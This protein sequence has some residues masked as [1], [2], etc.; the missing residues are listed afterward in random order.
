[1]KISRVFVCLAVLL[2]PVALSKAEPGTAQAGWQPEVEALKARVELLEASNS[3]LHLQIDALGSAVA[4]LTAQLDALSDLDATVSDLQDLLQHFSRD[5]DDLFLTAANLHVVSGTDSTRSTNGLGNIII[6][7]NE[8]R[9]PDDDGP[10]PDRTPRS[11]L[12]REAG[13][14]AMQFGVWDGAE[15]E[16][17]ITRGHDIRTGS[18]NLILGHGNNYSTFGGIVTGEFNTISGDWACAIGGRSNQASGWLSVVVGGVQNKAE[19][20]SAT[21]AGGERN[22][23]SGFLGTVAGGSRNEAALVV[24]SVFGG[25]ENTADGSFSSV[26][27][28]RMNQASGDYSGVAGGENNVATGVASLVSEGCGRMVDACGGP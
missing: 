18:H 1:M 10:D 3:E 19:Q 27:G 14:Q 28:G 16:G 12:S 5:G 8:S 4:G 20:T 22:I 23:V 11:L 17:T 24:S 15:V 6:G 7:Y 26:C 2:L 13:S 21:I 25:S 9:D